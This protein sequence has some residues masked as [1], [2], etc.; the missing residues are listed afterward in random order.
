MQF[1]VVRAG[2][3]FGVVLESD[4]MPPEKSILVAP[5]FDGIPSVGKLT[6]EIA[7]EGV[8]YRLYICAMQTVYR[9]EL[10]FTGDEVSEHRDAIIA[11][12]DLLVTGI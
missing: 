7:Y 12:I 4:I 3:Q 2:S 5:L 8:N 9:S 11:A 6:P 1:E 10:V